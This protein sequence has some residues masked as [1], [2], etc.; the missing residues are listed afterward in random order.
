M[1]EW[2]KRWCCSP[3]MR[4]SMIRSATLHQRLHIPCLWFA[5]TQQLVE[6]QRSTI[7]G[8]W[9]R[10]EK[11]QNQTKDK[12]V[13]PL[14]RNTAGDAKERPTRILP[15]RTQTVSTL[16]HLK[17]SKPPTTRQSSNI[18]NLLKNMVKAFRNPGDVHKKSQD[19]WAWIHLKTWKG[20][21]VL[22]QKQNN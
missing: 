18:Q 11:S 4:V 5:A 2:V 22:T 8:E 7:Q 13:P 19:I 12:H 1:L 21:T 17:S 10:M 6:L 15:E 3:I 20:P 9:R 16:L 14:G